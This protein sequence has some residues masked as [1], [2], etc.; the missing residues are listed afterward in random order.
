MASSS[1]FS[2]SSPH[3]PH[4]STLVVANFVTLKLTEA[5]YFLWRK[6]ILCL[7]ESQGLV[8]FIDGTTPA[9]AETATTVANDANEGVTNPDYLLWKKSD[10]LVKG[11]ILGSL[12]EQVLETVVDRGES[13]T[14]RDIWECLVSEDYIGI[15]Y[16]NGSGA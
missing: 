4:P 11:W 16:N 9:P 15:T 1:S 3:Y 13:T 6:Q 2:S 10:L 7:L 12:S 5:N 8:G 14:A